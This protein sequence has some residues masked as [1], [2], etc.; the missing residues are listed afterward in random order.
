[1]SAENEEILSLSVLFLGEPSSGITSLINQCATAG[2]SSR[3]NLVDKKVELSQGTREM[4]PSPIEMNLYDS[5]IDRRLP[6]G[7]GSNAPKERYR[8]YRNLC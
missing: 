3:L 7:V 5:M 8:L 2:S 6:S 4:T 1:M